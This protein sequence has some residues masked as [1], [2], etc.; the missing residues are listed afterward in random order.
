MVDVDG[1]ELIDFNNNFTSLIHGHAEPTITRAVQGQLNSGTAF[2]F[3]SET[4][5]ELAELLCDRIPSMDRIRFVNSGS[6]AVMHAIKAVR[7]Y[8]GRPKI[9]KFEGAYH[10]TYDFAIHQ[11]MGFCPDY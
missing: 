9:A 7:A 6:E 4:E 11:S 10:G 3:S 1:N 5:V 2:S 8:T